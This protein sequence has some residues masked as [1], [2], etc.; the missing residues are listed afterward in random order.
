MAF[1]I[2]ELES[3]S[4]IKAHT[5]RIWEQRYNFLKPSRTQTNIRTY[6]N[7]ELKTLLNVALLNKYGY[8]I[9]RIDEMPSEQRAKAVLQLPHP[10]A[11]N[12]HLVNEMIG[13]MIDFKS[14]EFEELLNGHIQKNGIEKTITEII[15][16]FLEKVGILWQTNRI[17]PVQEHIVSNIIR[18]KIVSAIEELPFVRL[19]DPLFLLF[20]PE[21]E[22]HEM[23]LLFVYY[24]LRKKQIPVLYLGANVPLKD[25][26]YLFKIKAPKYTYLHLT[27]FPHQHNF[28]KY[29]S[30]LTER[31]ETSKILISGSFTQTY[32]K[33]IPP[34]VRFLQSFS[35]VISYIATLK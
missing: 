22:H 6:N 27:S 13:Y 20:L 11:Y 2:K 35:E 25:V 24:L 10:E 34:N 12:E 30:Q 29:L 18:Q 19:A 21:D 26:E 28:S 5:I 23:G 4:G 3:L 7:E 8:K 16:F 33:A 31:A 32:R 9:S 17:I 14:I 15:F 1:T